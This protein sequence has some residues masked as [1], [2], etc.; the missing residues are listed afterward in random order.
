MER[1]ATCWRLPGG[2]ACES[3]F[4]TAQLEAVRPGKHYAELTGSLFSVL[5]ELGW[6]TPRRYRQRDTDGLTSDGPT[7]DS[8]WFCRWVRVTLE[9]S[10]V[11][12]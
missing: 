6:S 7:V 10:E 1:E 12:V 8:T 9:T 11:A 5:F 3:C 4:E 2:E